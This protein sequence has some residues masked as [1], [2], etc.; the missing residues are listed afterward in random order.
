MCPKKPDFITAGI[1]LGILALSFSLAFS[2]EKRPGPDDDLPLIKQAETAFERRSYEKAHTLSTEAVEAYP[3]SL[4]AL[5][6]HVVTADRLDRLNGLL[7]RYTPEQDNPREELRARYTRGWAAILVRD[8]S[9]AER[10]LEKAMELAGEQIP[11][12]VAVADLIRKRGDSSYPKDKLFREYEAFVAEYSHVPRAHLSYLNALSIRDGSL[13]KRKQALE[14]AMNAPSRLPETY[15]RASEIQQE[16]FWAD[17]AEALEIIQDGLEEF[18]DAIELGLEKIDFLRALGRQGEAL[19]TA[20]RFIGIAPNHGD[21]LQK[22]IDLLR[23]LGRL[24]EAIERIRALSEVTHQPYITLRRPILLAEF[25][26]YAGRRDEAVKILQQAIS[27]KEAVRRNQ[28]ARRMLYSLN[29]AAPE[30]KVQLLPNRYF[31]RQRGN[32]CGPATLQTILRHWGIER[33]QE[34]IAGLVYTGIAGTPP[35]VLHHYA[36][37]VGLESAEF[38]GSDETWKALIDAG[39]PVLWLQMS[40]GR[41]GHYR[42]VFG[43]DDV[44]EEWLV[45]DPNYSSMTTISYENTEDTWVLPSLRRSMVL[46]PEERTGQDLLAG[47]HPAPLL[48]VTNWALY[49]ATGSNLFVRPIVGFLTNV[50]VACLLALF[51]VPLVRT[52]TFPNTRFK[53][54]YSAAAVMALIVPLNLIVGAFRV[55]EVVS[56]LLGVHL[57]L[58]TLILLFLVLA[59]VRP[60]AAD[61]LH[62]RESIGIAALVLATWLALSFIDQSPWETIVPL[63]IF[64]VGMPLLV[65]PR[66][67]LVRLRRLALQAYDGRAIESLRRLG[68][69]G[70]HYYAAFV[71]EIDAALSAGDRTRVESS[72]ERIRQVQPSLPSKAKHSLEVYRFSVVALD[73]PTEDLLRKLE[74]FLDQKLPEKQRVLAF[75]LLFSARIRMGT[76]EGT[77]RAAAEELLRELN[78]HAGMSL[79]GLPVIRRGGTSAVFLAV[80]GQALAA[81]LRLA[82]KESQDAQRAV[83]EK[84]GRRFWLPARLAQD[85]P[86]NAAGGQNPVPFA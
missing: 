75:A 9:A 26:H 51:I 16:G 73:T 12:E 34:E 47:L 77:D 22:E 79:P 11:F 10:E 61:Y 27:E 78:I 48:V 63:G 64:V 45:N 50:L 57:A 36:E 44:L 53:P 7:A 65:W 6:I 13:G 72:I 59:L 1:L 15:V 41:G 76:D 68:S 82:A 30:D 37:S 21:L 80:Y 85:F 20:R 4:T 40:G 46:F 24:D 33:G 84:W 5:R 60:I 25:L 17:P 83:W 23:D 54:W 29:M 32:Y 31:L 2:Q 42:V 43:Y 66:L 86:P 18:P 35:Q 8:D 49:I 67:R 71:A 14:T 19:E 58:V 38:A 28:T 81:A 3:E 56:A 62:P 55:N 52:V 70:A 69:D 74:R 39:Y